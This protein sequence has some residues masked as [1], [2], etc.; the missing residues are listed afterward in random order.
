MQIMNNISRFL[1]T[2]LIITNV[3][4]S[5]FFE[6]DIS[7]KI[8]VLLVPADSVITSELTQIFL[9][10]Y[11][12]GADHYN[13]QIVS[14]D[15]DT[16]EKLVLDTSLTRNQMQ[17]TLYPDT[18]EWRVKAYNSAYSTFYTTNFLIVDTLTNH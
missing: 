17:F 11:I 8:V 16:A 15:F 13:L 18:F 14:P 7:D 10:E 4:C 2:C 3:G 9:W 1:I 12:D 6:E 5:A